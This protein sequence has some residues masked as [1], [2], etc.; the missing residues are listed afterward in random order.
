MEGAILPAIVMA[1]IILVPSIASI[2][3]L[4]AIKEYLE[5]KEKLCK[6]VDVTYDLINRTNTSA[7]L[8]ITIRNQ[9]K[10]PVAVDLAI[11]KEFVMLPWAFYDD[12][13]SYAGE[14][15]TTGMTIRYDPLSCSE[16]CKDSS[17]P[18]RLKDLCNKYLQYWNSFVLKPNE[19]KEIIVTLNIS[20]RFTWISQEWGARACVGGL[21]IPS[22]SMGE[23][24]L[25][26]CVCSKCS[27]TSIVIKDNELLH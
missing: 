1:T 5:L 25:E 3:M 17:C 6:C 27:S 9:N 16:E 15:L 22:P 18:P 19:K 21:R 8:K 14:D 20:R 10:Y 24:K 23:C 12:P 26:G 4:S 2:A 11:A 7:T 13:E